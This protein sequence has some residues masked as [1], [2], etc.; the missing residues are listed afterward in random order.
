MGGGA[1]EVLSE[2]RAITSENADN[3]TASEIEKKSIAIDFFNRFG[4]FGKKSIE[5][6]KNQSQM[7][8][9]KINRR[10]S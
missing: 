8:R 7:G 6:V 2:D 10:D 9:L 3:P 5:L 4:E 1:P